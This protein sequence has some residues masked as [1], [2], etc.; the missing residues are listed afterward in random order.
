M[1]QLYDFKNGTRQGGAAD[2]MQPIVANLTDEDL[3]AISAYL[4]SLPP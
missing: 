1:R 4:A 2:V 3:V